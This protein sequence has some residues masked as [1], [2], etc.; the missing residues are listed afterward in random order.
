MVVLHEIPVLRIGAPRAVDHELV[1]VRAGNQLDGD[2]IDP[3]SL[4]LQ[5][6]L[7]GGIPVVERAGQ[8]NGL[9]G[10][11]AHGERDRLLNGLGGGLG[12]SPGF[13]YTGVCT[14]YKSYSQRKTDIKL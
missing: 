7:A 10:F 14:V 13:G 2:G 6:L 9:A 11:G 1:L 8:I 12:G 5:H 3:V 4:L